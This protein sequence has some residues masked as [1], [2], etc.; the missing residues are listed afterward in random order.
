LL[1][2]IFISSFTGFNIFAIVFTPIVR[3]LGG[4]LIGMPM[5]W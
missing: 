5:G 1:G 2:L 3:I 4:F